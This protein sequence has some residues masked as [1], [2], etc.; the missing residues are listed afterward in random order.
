MIL[1]HCRESLEREKIEERKAGGKM[2]EV[3]W[4]RQDG[5]KMEREKMGGKRRWR[6]GERKKTEGEG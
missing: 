5:G 6:K 2:G 4:G 3:R 1:Q